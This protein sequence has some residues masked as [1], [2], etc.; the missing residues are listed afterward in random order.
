MRLFY[1]FCHS[2]AI[3]TNQHTTYAQLKACR[4]MLPTWKESIGKDKIQFAMRLDHLG[5]QVLL[6]TA[7]DFV[8]YDSI[9]G[10]IHI[11]NNTGYLLAS[12]ATVLDDHVV[13]L[14][15]SVQALAA[16]GSKVHSRECGTYT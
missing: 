11:C 16:A 12:L 13:L 2:V 9:K 8:V 15:R 1:R 10:H 7:K 3:L 6:N 14:E 5:N 4:G